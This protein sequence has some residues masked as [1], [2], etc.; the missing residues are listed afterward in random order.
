MDTHEDEKD[1]KKLILQ[2]L[3]AMLKIANSLPCDY[4]VIDC[5]IQLNHFIKKIEKELEN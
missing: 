1:K 3:K 4:F 5:E 2:G